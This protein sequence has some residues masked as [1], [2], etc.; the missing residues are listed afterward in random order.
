MEVK[1]WKYF[2]LGSSKHCF[3]P[4]LKSNTADVLMGRRGVVFSGNCH[5]WIAMV[6]DVTPQHF[7][8]SFYDVWSLETPQSHSSLGLQT[9]HEFCSAAGSGTCNSWT[10]AGH[11]LLPENTSQK[12]D[13]KTPAW[14]WQKFPES[15]IFSW[16]ILALTYGHESITGSWLVRNHVGL[17]G[18]EAHYG[19][20]TT[21]VALCQ[22]PVGKL[23]FVK[24]INLCR[25]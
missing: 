7:L 24:E 12:T 6:S 16:N 11:H 21:L 25:K 8:D 9:S 17:V 10:K 2:V 15:K 3:S 13:K 19:S 18:S 4:F 22:L 23:A 20:W 1:F 14:I 5:V